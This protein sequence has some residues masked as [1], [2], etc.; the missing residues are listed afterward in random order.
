[1]YKL[2]TSVCFDVITEWNTIDTASFHPLQASRI[3]SSQLLVIPSNPVTNIFY[4]ILQIYW[5][6]NYASKHRACR[7]HH[8]KVPE[9][10]WMADVGA[11]RPGWRS[12]TPNMQPLTQMTSHMKWS[13]QSSLMYFWIPPVDLWHINIL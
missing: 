11:A 5:M 1:M 2:K 10:P 8:P 3:P 9:D 12:E 6:Q 7:N 4:H 13:L